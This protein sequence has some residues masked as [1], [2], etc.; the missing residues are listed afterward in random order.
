[1]SSFGDSYNVTSFI[2]GLQETGVNTPGMLS[3]GLDST[4]SA[5]GSPLP[6]LSAT[7][8]GSTGGGAQSQ[9]VYYFEVVPIS[10]GSTPAPVQIGITATASTATSTSGSLQSGNTVVQ[11]VVSGAAGTEVDDEANLVYGV[12]NCEPT[13][14]TS[15]SSSTLGAGFVSTPGVD[16]AVI[17]ESGSSMS[18]GF[19]ETGT[20]SEFTNILYK[21][22]LNENIQSAGNGGSSSSASIDPMITIPVGYELELSP[23]IGNGAA[24]PVPEPRTWT[25]LLAGMAVLIAAQRRM[26]TRASRACAPVR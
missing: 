14:V 18:G 10:G 22:S 24:S 26:V 13:C 21:V 4:V 8:S 11:L 6:T 15:N 1:L 25:A 17:A 12:S 2:L 19:T 23:G 3:V 7:V 5:M 9:F 16:G 20:Y